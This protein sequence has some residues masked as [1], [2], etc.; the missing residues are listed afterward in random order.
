[1]AAIA[2]PEGKIIK[3]LYRETPISLTDGLKVLDDII[4]E[5]SCGERISG[6]G[7]AIGGPLDHEKGIVSPLHQPEWRNVPLKQIMEDRWHCPVYIDV[8][9]N[10]AALG[11]YRLTNEKFK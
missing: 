10:V 3:Q 8:D 7:I 4:N 6:I 2:N 1:M 9:T 5:L 11:E